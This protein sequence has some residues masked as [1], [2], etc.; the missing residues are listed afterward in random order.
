MR[1]A[2]I[3][4]GRVDEWLGGGHVGLRDA[5]LPSETVFV[6]KRPEK[7]EKERGAGNDITETAPK[8]LAS[9]GKAA[10]EPDDGETPEHHPGS[11]S[12]KRGENEKILRVEKEEGGKADDR[13]DFLEQE[14]AA[15]RPEKA[16]KT[17]TGECEKNSVQKAGRATVRQ[18][19]HRNK[20]GLRAG[21]VGGSGGEIEFGLDADF[22]AL[23]RSLARG[24]LGGGAEASAGDAGRSR[25]NI[26]AILDHGVFDKGQP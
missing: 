17:G 3:K 9:I 15:K 14:L 8:K 24:G 10:I 20:S 23:G 6:P 16:D 18:R 2:R 7:T 5:I 25:G 13:V 19:S 21:A 11:G 1:R 4:R 22:D 26:K 12:C